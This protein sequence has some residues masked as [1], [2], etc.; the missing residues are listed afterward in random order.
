MATVF[1]SGATGVIGRATVPQLLASGHTV[2]V[3]SRSEA[4]DA[5]I[6]ALGAEPVRGICLTRIRYAK[7]L[8]GQ[9]PFS[10]SP[11]ASRPVP[12]CDG[13]PPGSRTI[14]FA[15]KV[16]RT[17]STRPSRPAHK[18]SSIPASPSFIPTAATHGSTPYRP[19]SL[20]PT[21]SYQ[22]S[23]LSRSSAF[24]G[25]RRARNLAATRGA[26]R[27]R[28]RLDPGAATARP[29]RDFGV[30]QPP[31][32]IHADD[33]DRRRRVGSGGRAQ[34]RSLRAL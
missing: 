15:L 4:N 5:A 29:P 22:P 25:K 32:S 16:R 21:S 17:L 19:P 31:G 3:L 2:R 14:A 6:R 20:P 8:R 26:L 11:R 28:S 7:R 9:M 30:R 10:I 27:E 1:V 12:I 23:P 24:R 33:L 13:A 18:F 34:P